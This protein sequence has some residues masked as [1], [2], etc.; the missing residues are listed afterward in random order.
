MK[1]V[2]ASVKYAEGSKAYDEAPLVCT[3]GW[4]GRAGDFAGHRAEQGLKL[5]GTYWQKRSEEPGAYQPQFMQRLP[6]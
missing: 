1:H 6:E 2:I 5:K 3:C 4:S